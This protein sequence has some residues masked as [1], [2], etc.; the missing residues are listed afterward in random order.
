[1]TSPCTCPPSPGPALA[2]PSASP[3]PTVIS[4]TARGSLRSSIALLRAATS[5][6]LHQK[7]KTLHYQ[8]SAPAT[9]ADEPYD[10][11]H[12]SRACPPR[13]VVWA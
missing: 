3:R 12:L 6:R 10:F 2:V 5:T 13:I 11:S 9:N 4:T 1:M 8:P 7:N